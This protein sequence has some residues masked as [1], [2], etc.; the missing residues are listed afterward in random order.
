MLVALETDLAGWVYPC[1]LK[2]AMISSRRPSTV[3]YAYIHK[4]RGH[5][6]CIQLV[7]SPDSGGNYCMDFSAAH[8][9]GAVMPSLLYVLAHWLLEAEPT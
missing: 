7:T 8:P 2:L 4:D 3:L 9:T 1:P 6:M 5:T